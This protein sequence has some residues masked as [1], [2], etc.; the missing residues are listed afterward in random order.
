MTKRLVEFRCQPVFEDLVSEV[1]CERFLV[2]YP[3][4]PVYWHIIVDDN[5]NVTDFNSERTVDLSEARYVEANYNEERTITEGN[6]YIWAKVCLKKAMGA[7]EGATSMDFQTPFRLLPENPY[8]FRL[9]LPATEGCWEH[10]SLF[11]L[12]KPLPFEL[13]RLI[14]SYL[15]KCRYCDTLWPLSKMNRPFHLLKKYQSEYYRLSKSIIYWCCPRCSKTTLHDC[16][17][18]MAQAQYNY[19][20]SF[21]YSSSSK[22]ITDFFGTKPKPVSSYELDFI[23]PEP[24]AKKK[25]KESHGD[26]D[27]DSGEEVLFLDSPEV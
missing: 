20:H 6:G 3:L 13:I 7:I 8:P 1:R 16:Q 5:G 26:T 24:L 14:S 18:Q 22:K 10:V 23:L 19:K 17:L 2:R 25:K 15:Q 11:R 27:S 4:D 21:E 12:Y 9:T